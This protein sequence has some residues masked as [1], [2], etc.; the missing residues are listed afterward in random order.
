M[1]LHRLTQTPDATFGQLIGKD[2]TPLGDTLELPWK[3]NQHAAS[4]IPA[5]TYL[6]TRYKSPKHGYD[7]WLL[8]GVPNRS[9]VEIHIGNTVHD[10]DGC[11]LVGSAFGWV[12]GQHGV[13]GSG[14]AFRKLM[15]YTRAQDTFDLQVI[16]PSP[17]VV[18]A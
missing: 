13:T 18:S 12:N 17:D 2:G 16:D 8:N 11:I 4:C 9:M 10:T 14:A 5:G 7:V 6:C 1:I 15:E 3:D